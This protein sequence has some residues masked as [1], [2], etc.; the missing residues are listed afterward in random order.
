MKKV[1]FFVV[2]IIVFLAVCLVI[3]AG[4][5]WAAHAFGIDGGVETLISLVLGCAWGLCWLGLFYTAWDRI[6][7]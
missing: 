6:F 7:G 5:M 1:W 3:A 2:A 4:V